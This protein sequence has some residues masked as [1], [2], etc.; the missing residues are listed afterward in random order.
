METLT[1][2]LHDLAQISDVEIMEWSQV[3]PDVKSSVERAILS[4]N[5]PDC[6]CLPQNA[7]AVAQ[8]VKYAHQNHL[9]VIILGQG[10]KINWGN[11]RS[12]GNLVI[13]TAKLN[14]IVEHSV[15]DFTITVEAGMTLANLQNHLRSF[16]QYLPIDPAYPDQ[17]T[18][19]G[20]MATADGGSLRHKYHGIRDLILGIS[21]V[22]NDGEI[23]KAG[24]KVVKNVAGYDLMKLLTG[25]YGSLGIITEVTLRLYPLL[26]QGQTVL[27]TGTA[28]VIAPVIQ[29]LRNSALTP[30]KAD[31][32]SASL[33]KDLQLGNNMGLLVEFQGMLESINTQVEQLET[34]AQSCALTL[35][36]LSAIQVKELETK[37]NQLFSLTS[38]SEAVTCKIGVLPSEAVPT[39]QQLD[40]L[41]LSQHRGIIHL[42]SGIGKIYLQQEKLL[43]ALKIMRS[44][45]QDKQGYLIILEAP[46]R[47]KKEFD[48]FG[49]QG[50]T[51]TIMQKIKQ[52]FDPQN[53]FNP[54]ILV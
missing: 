35:E 40:Q 30:I 37:L 16:K 27:I 44:H 10:S 39:L 28:E 6:L 38:P 34:M 50:N 54:H 47:V 12:H 33:I 29:K 24:G 23:A 51:L 8:I 14:Q 9:S 26:D 1:N 48:N 42:G 11:L 19:G 22:R 25:S 20:I 43:G 45:C 31:L 18:L 52:Q 46:I 7:Q 53:M 41:S 21:F 17:A 36:L 4:S 32:L 3:K 2:P 5:K 15:G 13:A 49:N